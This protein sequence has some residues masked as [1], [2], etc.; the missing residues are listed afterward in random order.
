ME[1]VGDEII[2][3]VLSAATLGEGGRIVEWLNSKAKY[4]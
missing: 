3:N 4:D 2:Q 1:G